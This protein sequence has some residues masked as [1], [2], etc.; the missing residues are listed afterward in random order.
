MSSDSVSVVILTHNE[1]QH[2]ERCINSVRGIADDIVIVDSF[3]SDRTVEI[4]RGLGARVFQNSW[5][6]YATQFQWA[7]DNTDIQTEWIMRLDADE[8]LETDAQRVRDC[9]SAL[10]V[11]QTG[12]YIRRKY[13]FLGKWIK[14]GAMYPIYVL[15][16]W[17]RKAGRIENRW[18]DEHIVLDYGDTTTTDIDIVDDN[19]N[20]VTWWINKHNAY[21][22]REMIDILND[23]Y[24]FLPKDNV[25]SEDRGSQAGVKRL[26][27][28]NVY[29]HLPVFV[30][31][32]LFFLYRY[33][34]RLG[35]LDG[36]E[37]YAF[38][39][40]QCFWYRNLVDLKVFE[41]RKAIGNRRNPS[42]IKHIIEG[43]TGLEL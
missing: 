26:L 30:R 38:H 40:M 9:L 42:E 22:T 12:L 21:A 7:L 23:E 34:F 29:N 41:M 11:C 19:R 14:R 24:S 16:F 2:I 31:P 37:G 27:K 25:L 6:N 10:Q 17:R 5:K 4:G 18:M 39:F 3:S 33:L 20:T 13:F 36:A 15:R 28:E 8:Y 32:A 35:F 1:E 43:Q